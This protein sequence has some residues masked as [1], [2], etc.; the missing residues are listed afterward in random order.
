MK[1]QRWCATAGSAGLE[2]ST[3]W[4]RV[5]R[6]CPRAPGLSGMAVAPVPQPK[7]LSRARSQRVPQH[8]AGTCHGPGCQPAL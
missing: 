3:A 1:L 5:A 4:G 6:G 7:A 8:R 2:V